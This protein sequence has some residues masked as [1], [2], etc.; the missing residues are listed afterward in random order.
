MRFVME[1]S[2]KCSECGAKIVG[3]EDFNILD[4]HYAVSVCRYC[5]LERK[6]RSQLKPL[7]KRVE[8]ERLGMDRKS[9]EEL[10]RLSGLDSK[11]V[12]AV[13]EMAAV[14]CERKRCREWSPRECAGQIRSLKPIKKGKVR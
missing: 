5:W 2:D 7:Y 6:E 11:T 13:L 10:I 8:I 3:K 1:N 14:L 9:T 4:G 12:S